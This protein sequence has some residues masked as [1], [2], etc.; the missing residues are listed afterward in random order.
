MSSAS[1][2]T[3]VVK[4]TKPCLMQV[5]FCLGAPRGRHLVFYL[6]TIVQ[7]YNSATVGPIADLLQ[8]LATSLPRAVFHPHIENVSTTL[9]TGTCGVLNVLSAPIRP[10]TQ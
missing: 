1:T 4:L 6:L 8:R 5:V 3:T 7:G 2:K 9:G 10:G